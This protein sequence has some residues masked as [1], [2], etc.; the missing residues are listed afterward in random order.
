[1]SHSAASEE[2][3]ECWISGVRTPGRQKVFIFFSGGDSFP[4]SSSS[5]LLLLVS[6]RPP[7]FFLSWRYVCLPLS[8]FVSSVLPRF[9]LRGLGAFSHL[10]PFILLRTSLLKKKTCVSTEVGEEK[11]HKKERKKADPSA[12]PSCFFFS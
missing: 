3:A 12:V 4:S 6:S 8:F 11:Q 1:M 2:D 9:I 10:V 7:F 5:S